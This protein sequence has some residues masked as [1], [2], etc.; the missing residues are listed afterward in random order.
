M[1]L[2]QDAKAF[3]MIELLVVIAI[4]AVLAAL[5]LPAL[6]SAK[7]A[8]KSVGCFNNLRQLHLSWRTAVDDVPNNKR[9]I[10]A[11]RSGASN[12]AVG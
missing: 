9:C 2:A 11:K 5:L 6:A 10:A 1:T 7:R 8:A 12:Y 4:I 3:T